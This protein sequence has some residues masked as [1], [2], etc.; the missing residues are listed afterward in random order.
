MAGMV[1][2]IGTPDTEWVQSS[3]NTIAY[4]GGAGEAVFRHDGAVVGQV[5]PAAQGAFATGADGHSVALDGEVHNWTELSVGS[6]CALEA[7]ETAYEVR[8]P[9]FVSHLDGPFALAVAGPDGTL[10]AR[11]RVGK[12]PLYLQKPGN[13]H[14]RFASEAKALIGGEGEIT[15]FPPGH[16]Y[17]ADGGLVRFA[18][19]QTRPPV[20]LPEDEVAEELRG[21]LVA[22]V[23]KRLSTGEVGAW[24]S[25]GIDSASLTALAR[26]QV[27][28]LKTFA[29][30]V[31]GAPDLEYAQMVSEFVGTEHHERICGLREM[32][33]ILPA[34]VYYLE[35]FD[36]LLVRSSI[37]NFLVG[38]LASEH[39][40]AVLS[41]E[42]GD[43]LFA[44]YAYLK[45][46][47]PSELPGELVDITRRLHNTA[48]QRVDRCSASHGLVARTAFLDQ[49]VLDYALQIP[50]AMKIR[51]NGSIVEKWILRRAVDGLLPEEVL[52]RTKSKFWQGAGVG[53]QLQAYAEEIISDAEFAAERELPDGL[54][55][56]T[57]EELYYY[58]IFRDIFGSQLGAGLVG[59]TKGAPAEK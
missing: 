35:S 50:A 9:E 33:E 25:G 48:L 5:W 13:G 53:E 29:A 11:D 15:E 32:L 1:G 54:T 37:T 57:K 28:E 4:R 36:A 58:R 40:P 43:E 2:I 46:L 34:V 12:S 17:T 22:S 55:I 18:R 31:E 26:R 39:V 45:R 6:T 19:I 8:G 10:L 47:E 30:G 24:L 23:E 41:G 16:Y 7:I 42:G 20:D 52:N 51:D 3:L 49:D 59:R 38:R 21:R 14:V 27:P 56:N 44:G